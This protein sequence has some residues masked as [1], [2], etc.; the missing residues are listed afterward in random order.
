MRVWASQRSADRPCRFGAAGR[1]VVG[2][3][4][5]SI[6]SHGAS[7][8]SIALLKYTP[9][10]V[11]LSYQGQPERQGQDTI[12]EPPGCEFRS[13]GRGLSDNLHARESACTSAVPQRPNVFEGTIKVHCAPKAV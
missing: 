2:E 8:V 13:W 9:C 11:G 3:V 10:S 12:L 6:A 1:E 7:S 5:G 4:R